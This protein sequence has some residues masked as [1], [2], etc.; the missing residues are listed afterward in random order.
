M[1]NLKGRFLLPDG[2]KP[3]DL[4]SVGYGALDEGGLL[5]AKDTVHQAPFLSAAPLVIGAVAG[6]GVIGASA[7]RLA[8][9]LRS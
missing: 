5:G 9:D 1:E 2:E 7:G 3:L 8:A 6:G 4:S